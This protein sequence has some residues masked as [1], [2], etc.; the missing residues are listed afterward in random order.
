MKMLLMLCTLII[1]PT[2]TYAKH[3]IT[4]EYYEISPN[5]IKDVEK[6][7]VKHTP[8][9]IDGHK[10][11]AK[12]KWSIQT[13]FTGYKTVEGYGVGS[14]NL[15]IKISYVMPRLADNC[16]DEEIVSFFNAAYDKL[17]LHEKGH[18]QI[19]IDSE[20]MIKTF[21]METPIQEDFETLKTVFYQR[22]GEIIN[23]IQDISVQYDKETEHGF[24][25][26]AHF[27]VTK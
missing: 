5:S 12:T 9:F 17:H 21:L 6:Q 18:G 15:D 16:C 4:Y 24:T 22:N 11:L 8:V 14:I 7:A 2:V 26:G 13:G 20:Q 27:M 23:Q 1:L 19:A 3:A 25:Q 10:Y